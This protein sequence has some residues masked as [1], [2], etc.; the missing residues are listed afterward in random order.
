MNIRL[1]RATI[2]TITT[3]ILI[4]GLFLILNNKKE[5]RAQTSPD[6]IAVRVVPNPEMVSP[7]RWYLENIRNQ[8]S[9][10]QLILDGYQAVRD[11]RS[12]Y[13]SAANVNPN[14]LFCSTNTEFNTGE[15]E[16][17]GKELGDDCYY[18]SKKGTCAPSMYINIYIISYTQA[19][20]D[21]GDEYSATQDIFGQLLNNWTFNVNILQANTYG[22]CKKVEDNSETG[23]SCFVD[24][25][26]NFSEGEYCASRKASIVRDVKRLAD[27][28]DI[29]MYLNNYYTVANIYPKLDAGSY[30]PN[31]SIS[32]WP[33]WQD[34]LGASLG[35]T[36]PVDPLN[37]LRE[38][39]QPYDS[40]TCWN[41]NDQTFNGS[42][43]LN[44]SGAAGNVYQYISKNEGKNYQLCAVMETT[45]TSGFEGACT[46]VNSEPVVNQLPIIIAPSLIILAEGEALNEYI[47]A[48]DPD[49]TI[50]SWNVDIG[51][52][53]ESTG[54]YIERILK[55]ASFASGTQTTVTITVGDNNGVTTKEITILVPK[56]GNNIVEQGESCD[57]GNITNSDGCNDKCKLEQ[58][59]V[60]SEVTIVED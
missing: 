58:N 44:S 47:Q 59:V 28:R 24:I 36:L 22:D 10:S 52:E 41:E 15:D 19:L 18:Y 11:G 26:C 45:Y 25:H 56:C 53:L 17:D 29:E 2:L 42:V 12:V 38:C 43:P 35:V 32:V 23:T 39:V 40:N 30:L 16:C 5:A 57:D 33:S 13:V 49:G 27:I 37:K 54:S 51:Y 21:G 31:K 14:S 34:T 55:H 6:A 7:T 3:C 60:I 9:P 1:K 8:G 48:Y 50:K 4:T 20:P 46:G